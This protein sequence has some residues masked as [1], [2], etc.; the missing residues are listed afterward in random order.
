MAVVCTFIKRF[1]HTQLKHT[2]TIR[3]LELYKCLD[4][5]SLA[6]SV[7]SEMNEVE[8]NTIYN[9]LSKT[10]FATSTLFSGRQS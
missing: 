8:W 7:G 5:L 9:E 6:F 10:T 2:Y 3:G 1:I 4:G